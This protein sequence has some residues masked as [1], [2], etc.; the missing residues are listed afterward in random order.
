MQYPRSGH[1]CTGL[2]DGR[3][4]VAGGTS[5]GAATNSAEIFDPVSGSW[6][7]A[8]NMAEARLSHT[9]TLLADGRVLIAGGESAP[10]VARSTLEIFEPATGTFSLLPVQLSSPRENHAAALLTDGRVFISGGSNG[11]VPLGS[12]D[13]FDPVTGGVSSGPS[14]SAPRFKHSATV[15]LDGRVLLAGGSNGSADLNSAEVY[16]PPSGSMTG[17]GSLMLAR[18]GHVA[19]LLPKNN[20]VLIAGGTSSGAATSSAELFRP[21]TNA[22]VTTGPMSA[23]RAG[24]AGAALL[25]EGYALAAGGS[26]TATSDLYGFATVKTDQEDNAPGTQVLITGRDWQPGEAVTLTLVEVPYFDTHPTLTAVADAGGNISNS[27]FAPDAH[28]VG[29]RFFLTATGS[30]SQAQTSF[31]DAINIT[32]VTPS[33]GPPAG[34]MAVTIKSSNGFPSG[35]APFTATFDTTTVA[36]TRVDSDTLTATTPAHA[37]GAVNVKVTDKTGSNATLA[38]GFTYI[39]TPSISKAFGAASVSLNSTTSLTFTITNPNSATT[40]TGVDFTDSLPAGMA[41]DTTPGVVNGCGGTFTATAGASSVSLAGGTVPPAGCIISVTVKGTTAGTKNN[42]TTAVTSTNGGTGNTASATLEVTVPITINTT[43]DGSSSM[44]SITVDGVTSDAPQSFNWSAGSSHTIAVPD[45]QNGGAGIQFVWTSWSGTPSNT[46]ESQTITAPS[47]ATTYTANFKTQYQVTFAQNGI[48]VDSTG[49]VVTVNASAKTA[50]VLP[51]SAFFD[52]G[53]AVTYA[54]SDPVASTVS[55]KRYTLTSP[56]PTPATPITLSAPVTVT[57][58][59]KVQYQITF[60]QAGIGGDSTG[61]IVTVAGNPK[62]AAALPFSD[63]FDSGSSL[64]YS[65]SEPVPSTATGKRYALTTPAPAPATPVTVSASATVTGTYKTQFQITFAQAGIGGDSTGTIVTVAANAKTAADL[66]FSDWFDNGSSLTYSYA[67][68]VASSVS[69]KRYG[70][71]TPA[72]TPISPINVSTSATVTGTYKTQFQITFAQAGIGG[73]STG[74]VVTVDG[75]PKTASVLPFSDWFDNA[76]S[77]TYA[78][79]DP[80]AST[81]T[82]KRYALTTPAASPV[83]AIAVSTSITVTGTYKAQ[84]QI[85]FAQ[86]GIGADSTGTVV[87]VAGVPKTAGDLSFTT[88]WLDDG[89][90]LIYLYANPVASTVSG[91]RYALTTPAPTPANPITV[92]APA[93]ITGTYKIQFQITFAQSGIGSD[94]TG[95]VVT[96]AG[97]PKIASALPFNDWFDSGSSLTYTFADPVTS[98]VSGKRYA[99]TTLAATPTSPITVSSSATVTGTYK[100]QYQIIFAQSGIGGDTAGNTV[101]TIAGAP[102]T[103]ASLP[104]TTDWLDSGSSLAYSYADPVLSTLAGK[105]YALT[106]P[107]PSPASP[108]TVSAP[109]TITGT[110]NIQYQ[111]TFTQ[112]GIGLDSTG[113]VVTVAGAP[114]TATDLPFTTGWLD[115]GSALTYGYADPV[116]STVAGKRYALTAPAP[117]PLSP[118]T[119]SAPA[120]VTGSYKVQYQIA[121][122]QTG[123]SGDSA[124]ALLT[125]TGKPPQS[126]LSFSNFFD[127]SSSVTFAYADPVPTSMT[128]K[129]YKLMSVDTASP[130]NV[131]AAVTITATYKTQYLLTLAITA[132]VPNGLSNISGGTTGTYYDAGS[133]FSLTAA[134]P[135]ADGPDKQWR[136]DNWSGTGSGASPTLP[137]TMSSPQSI[138]AN[139]VARYLLTLTI[140]ASVPGGVVNITGGT[141]GTF[142]DAGTALRLLAATPVPDVAAKRWRFDNWSGTTMGASPTLPVTMNSAQSIIANYVVQYQLTLATTVSVPNGLTNITGGTSGNFYDAGTMLNLGATTPVADG[143]G[144]RWRFNNWNGDATSTSASVPLTM[145]MPRSVTANYVVQYQLTLSITAGVPNGLGNITG[146]ATG[147][148]Y[149]GGTNLN[150]TAAATVA[151]GP[152]RLWRFNNWTGT[153]SGI[154]AMLPVGMSMPQAITANYVVPIV[155]AAGNQAAFE[156]TLT[157]FSLG[158]FIESVGIPW[159]VDINWGDAS[160]HTVFPMAA[161][162]AITSQ[163]HVFLDNV[164]S[165]YTVTVKVTDV[166]GA[167]DT[168]TFQVTVANVAPTITSVTGP[169]PVALGSP[170]TVQANFTDLGTLDTH[171]CQFSWND[172]SADTVVAAGGMGNGSCSA[173]HTYAAVGVYTVTV[174]VTDK[175]L[176]GASAPLQY[177][178]IYDASAGFVTGGGWINSPAGSYVANPSL[179]GKANFGFNSQYKKGQSTPDGQTEFQFQTGN[180]DFHST[181]YDWLVVAGAKAQFKGLGTVN[182]S[183]NY[184]FI[185]TAIDGSL[186]GGGTD[187][188]RIK[189]WDKQRRSDCV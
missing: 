1:I 106:T 39:G 22:F 103:A 125:V 188:F 108:I 74:T 26:G 185:L 149:D 50:A 135:V 75:N 133:M 88:D 182:G 136:F 148:F 105:R 171:T 4:L 21:W 31:T 120:T 152:G 2:A 19:M 101:V 62:T 29:I 16:D 18:Q 113:V 104:F 40:L 60:A 54:Y 95:T 70:L 12:S 130:L 172:S 110:Y 14:L 141:T 10:G 43:T 41:V 44:R 8:A 124:G 48:G 109:V 61:T 91:K 167:Y 57:G 159:S 72:P 140:T 169:L 35:Q 184:G 71:T 131:T 86:S 181:S 161:A 126:V 144:K 158:S 123:M 47:A 187:K 150:L 79:T 175:D 49:T 7:L 122:A 76:S 15:L 142:Y 156:G 64:P 78:Y 42:V 163:S 114:K 82:G 77:L 176:G 138:T 147:L 170:A 89:S 183:G 115:S 102:K 186:N 68:P 112:R 13:I 84:F 55:G 118:I 81:V 98:T 63:W 166:G 32:S 164:P 155:T 33:S 134:T 28:D 52:T 93:T 179:V 107:A 3:V 180:L 116:A 46:T 83:S 168:N 160:A 51:F 73:D 11:S 146:G 154:T 92:S 53:A 80:V 9:A 17:A 177:V 56:A 24:A 165:V 174:T 27:D 85:K 58:T 157:P 87:T 189:I 5:S 23:A 111:I 25:T 127:E 153:A 90:S 100:I 94:S 66:P 119:V 139:Y 97:S 67:D 38:N 6:S 178:V 45:P 69:G 59:Y 121:F 151:D 145:S 132:G 34:G 96:V 117:S 37:P 128:G 99:L 173:P 30:V 20:Q 137:V 162:G 129:R 65:Y 143:V 36:A